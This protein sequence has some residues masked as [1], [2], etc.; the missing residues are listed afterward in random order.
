MTALLPY[1]PHLAV[2][3][4][5]IFASAFFSCSEAALFYMNR[6]QRDRLATGSVA[7]RTAIQLLSAPDRL[8]TAILFWNLVTN[9][10]YFALASVV[11]I[12]LTQRNMVS[13]ASAFTV[14]SLLSVIV[15][16]EMLPK[17]VGVIWP[18]QL[19]ALVS[20]P[21]NVAARA[22][23]PVAGAFGV[24][25][26]GSVRVIVPTFQA[27]ASLELGDLE[28]AI[29]LSSDDQQVIEQERAV[30]SRIVALAETRIEEIMRPRLLYEAVA[31]PGLLSNLSEQA[32]ASGYVLLTEPDSEE[33]A[34]VVNANRAAVAGAKQLSTLALPVLPMPWCA[35]AADTL[36]RMESTGRDVAAVLNELGETI[37]IVTR[38]DLLGNVLHAEPARDPGQ[39]KL[40]RITAIA[41]GQW[42]V[43]GMT[44]LRRLAKQLGV[45]LPETK[46]ITVAGMLQEQLRRL[47]T[48]GD[49]LP[50]AGFEWEVVRAD[51]PRL[52]TATVKRL[53]ESDDPGAQI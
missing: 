12:D 22:L 43:T 17:N 13:H 6:E 21:L 15:F 36:S 31:P 14:V 27:E 51:D 48:R 35:S 37:G 23:D 28:R 29:N 34:A 7:Q 44:T 8:L 5:L 42:E 33:I 38:R 25:K 45:A 20:L 52:L 39:P 3:L 41:D 32:I 24:V 30:L 1:L 4:G 11:A 46:G 53:P 9:M 40:G 19:A 50:W 16:C 2:M 18:A 47:P 10:I 26:R 49:R